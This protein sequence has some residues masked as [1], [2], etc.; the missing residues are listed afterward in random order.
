MP[1]ILQYKGPILATCEGILDR[2]AEAYVKR[3]AFHLSKKWDKTYSQIVFWVRARLQLCILKS[4]SN[5][6]RG[7]RSKW[8][9]GNILDGAAMP[10]MMDWVILKSIIFDFGSVFFYLKFILV[11]YHNKL[12]SFPWPRGLEVCT[13][14]TSDIRTDPSDKTKA[15]VHSTFCQD[16]TTLRF[17]TRIFYFVT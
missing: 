12:F 4:V 7:S 13:P 5:C 15:F 10:F 16:F 2:E 14:I 6:F 8:R 17:L 3:L 1:N 11:F 9:G